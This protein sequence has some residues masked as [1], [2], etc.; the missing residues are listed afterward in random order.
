[1]LYA[2][3]MGI[4]REEAPLLPIPLHTLIKLR[5]NVYSCDEQRMELVTKSVRFSTGEDANAV[6]PAAGRT[7]RQQTPGTTV[8]QTRATKIHICMRI[9]VLHG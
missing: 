5:P 2:Y 6:S 7:M 4:K 1:M 9:S 3:L 8:S